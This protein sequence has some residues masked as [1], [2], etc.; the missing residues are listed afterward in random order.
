M[1]EPAIWKTSQSMNEMNG[2]ASALPGRSHLAPFLHSVALN[3]SAAT[4]SG[5]AK[6]LA[7]EK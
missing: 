6:P 4:A 2:G 5:R 1:V 7:G 3:L